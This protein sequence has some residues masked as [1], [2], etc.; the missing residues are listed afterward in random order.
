LRHSSTLGELARYFKS[1]G[2]SE[3]LEA[4]AGSFSLEVIP[5]V[6][7]DRT[8]FY[9]EYRHSF[10]PTSPAIPCFE[11]ALLYP[12]LGLL[13]ATNISEGRGTATPFRVAGAPW[14]DGARIAAAINAQ[15]PDGVLARPVS[16]LPAEGKFHGQKCNG[17]MFHIV[18]PAVF[19]PVRL[20]WLLIRL[21]R[22]LHPEFFAWATY[23]TYVNHKGTRHLDLLTGL[24]DAENLV[25]GHDVEDIGRYTQAGDWRDK[26]APCLLY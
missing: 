4:H 22:G 8:M 16:F 11:A 6:N 13:E 7:W 26:I 1:A 10:V 23:P 3:I 2:C 19:R 25:A 17:I 15:C 5:C 18:D 12:G 9:P 21:V 14:M 24:Q 20:G